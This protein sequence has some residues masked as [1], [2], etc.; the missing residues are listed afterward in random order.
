[1]ISLHVIP[2]ML[3]LLYNASPILEV[4]IWQRLLATKFQNYSFPGEFD[5]PNDN[6]H[7]QTHITTIHLLL[8]SSL[9]LDVWILGKHPTLSLSLPASN[10]LLL[11]PK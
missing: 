10:P 3:I 7:T 1:M 8:Y 11:Q 9:N 2:F 4:K 5:T 6:H